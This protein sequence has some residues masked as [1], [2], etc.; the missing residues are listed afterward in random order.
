MS[1]KTTL[2]S[3]FEDGDVPTGAQ[4]ADLIDSMALSGVTALKNGI[5]RV[6]LYGGFSRALR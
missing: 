5:H 1:D 3:F 2:K 6:H 4:F